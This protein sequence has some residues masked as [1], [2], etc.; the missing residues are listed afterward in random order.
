MNSILMNPPFSADWEQIEDDRFS[1]YGIAPKSKADFAF[2]LHGYSKLKSGGTMAIVLPHGVLFRGAAEGKIRKALLEEGA[3]KAIIGLPANI[4]YGTSIPTV[5]IILKKDREDKS[6]FFIDASKDFEKGK[7]K[8]L[9]KD[10]HIQKIFLTYQ[11]Q[12][13]IEKYSRLVE[14]DE[15]KDNDF[16]LN[17]PRYVDTFEEEE[18]IDMGVVA[19]EIMQIDA[20]IKKSEKELG[21]MLN[22]LEVSNGD[23]ELIQA[24]ELTKK[25][26]GVKPEKK[27]NREDQI[28]L[29]I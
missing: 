12:K 20:E 15:V 1:S 9:L 22:E 4:F 29:E 18:P 17:I 2:L 27:A 21:S 8:N 19:L 13:G 5:L 11:E 26:F 3:I 24:L 14:Y 28:T 25:M 7:N 16:N 10:E 23:P 6:V